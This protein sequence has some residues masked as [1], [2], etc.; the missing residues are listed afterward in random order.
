MTPGPRRASG[1]RRLPHLLA[2]LLLAT[3]A[4]LVP[5]LPASAAEADTIYSLLNDARAANGQNALARN[6]SLDQVA[7]AWAGQLAAAGVLSHNPNYP[8]QIPAGWSEAGENVARGQQNATEM[9]LAWMNSAGHRANILGNYT[10]VGV[11]WLT[12][13]S[14]MT[15]GVQ[16][17]ANYPA[18]AAPAPAAPTEDLETLSLPAAG[19][20]S[21]GE[22]SGAARAGDHVVKHRAEVRTTSRFTRSR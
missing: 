17:F 19:E 14:G 6:S 12:D 1:F 5:A 13:A 10:D 3:I 21:L 7:A 11:A 8:S 9:H 15:W 2:T 22:N 4:L 16:V 20:E 18:V